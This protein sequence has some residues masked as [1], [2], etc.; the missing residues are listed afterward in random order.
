LGYMVYQ[1]YVERFLHAVSVG[2][3]P[4]KYE[5]V[6][7]AVDAERARH[8]GINFL[9]QE[10]L[11]YSAVP[12]P[13]NP[14]ALAVARSAG[15]DTTPLKQWAE[16]A[17]DESDPTDGHR[18]RLEVLRTAASPSGRPLVLDLGDIVTEAE[19]PI[20]VFMDG[21]PVPLSED[22]LQASL[23]QIIDDE[24]CR[25]TGRVSDG[26]R[27]SLA[28]PAVIHISEA[29]LNALVTRTVQDAVNHVTGRVD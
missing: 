6:Q 19:S 28:L 9:Q 12:V 26:P 25:V 15:I 3:Q 10:L 16:R 8:S 5:F 4:K 17:L 27:S 1:M 18:Q 22:V 20:S 11:E 24:V 29:D 23:Q 2:F 21:D 13:A 14:N 7:A